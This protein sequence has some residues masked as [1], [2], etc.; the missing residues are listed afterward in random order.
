M[1]AP[2]TTMPDELVRFARVPPSNPSLNTFGPPLHVVAVAG[3][4]E[5]AEW[6]PAASNVS[7]V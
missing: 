7:T 2:C 4:S 6:S 1:L 5:S 3:G